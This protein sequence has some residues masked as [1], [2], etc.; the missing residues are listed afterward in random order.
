M[1]VISSETIELC[2]LCGEELDADN[3]YGTEDMPLCREHQLLFNA[4]LNF[5][6]TGQM[7][8]PQEDYGQ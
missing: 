7:P 5:L 1:K 8:L 2:D 4:T 6:L 3:C